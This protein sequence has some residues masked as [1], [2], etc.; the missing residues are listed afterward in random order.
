MLSNSLIP[1]ELFSYLLSHPELG[2]MSY[3]DQHNDASVKKSTSETRTFSATCFVS[4]TI[5]IQHTFIEAYGTLTSKL[6][7]N[8]TNIP[9]SKLKVHTHI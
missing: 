4:C 5:N 2:A 6:Y 1:S 8:H 3:D 7:Y 9:L